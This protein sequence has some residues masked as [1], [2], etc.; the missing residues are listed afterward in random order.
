[1][2]RMDTQQKAQTIIM[3]IGI[4]RKER[5]QFSPKAFSNLIIWKRDA[6]PPLYL[7]YLNAIGSR[8]GY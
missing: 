7:T 6:V 1:M 5:L 3:R 4:Q 8:R 2:G